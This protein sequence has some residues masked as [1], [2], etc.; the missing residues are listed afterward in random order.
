MLH[1]VQRKHGS[2]CRV[3]GRRPRAPYD[4][5]C[6]VCANEY[7][8]AYRERQRSARPGTSTTGGSASSRGASDDGQASPAPPPTRQ[9]A[10]AT[11]D[12]GPP[13][14]LA[15]TEP[16]GADALSMA[17]APRDPAL[18]AFLGFLGTE[19]SSS[20]LPEAGLELARFVGAVAEGGLVAEGQNA[21]FATG[22][23]QGQ[24]IAFGRVIGT[25]AADGD[26]EAATMF[27]R[28]LFAA[29]GALGVFVERAESAAAPDRAISPHQLRA[30]AR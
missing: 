8:K 2:F 1:A 10:R 5:R 7:M 11:D 23:V 29:A 3:C 21:G 12:A 15:R 27:Q 14:P 19:F 30:A 24:G 13:A 18:A 20:D 6:R 9:S 22:T 26:V 28:L 17:A 25:R 4:S 16:V